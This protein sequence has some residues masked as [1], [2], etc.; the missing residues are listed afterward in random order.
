MSYTIKRTESPLILKKVFGFTKDVYILAT[1]K[2]DLLIIDDKQGIVEFAFDTA[3]RNDI[4]AGLNISQDR[5]ILK[6]KGEKVF[7][8]SQ[9]P[10]ATKKYIEAKK[11]RCVIENTGK[12]VVSFK[13]SNYINNKLPRE[14]VD[15]VSGT[16]L[17]WM[18]KKLK[19]LFSDYDVSDKTALEIMRDDFSLETKKAFPRL[20]KRSIHDAIT[21]FINNYFVES[22]LTPRLAFT[23]ETILKGEAQVNKNKKAYYIALKKDNSATL[24]FV[25][26]RKVVTAMRKRKPA[27]L[28]PL[29]LGPFLV[30][31]FGNRA[32]TKKAL[33][34]SIRVM[35]KMRSDDKQIVLETKVPSG[36][37]V[38]SE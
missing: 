20:G 36:S 34:F 19:P 12:I 17:S 28:Y 15:P 38:E 30:D 31:D 14:D 11:G 26:I 24:L 35:N 33:M 22:G 21:Q 3:P 16:I 25:P 37:K 7:Y 10:A 13:L 23:K 29:F 8:V 4:L 32:S 18:E 1:K 27:Q 9:H 6:R 2:T 5:I